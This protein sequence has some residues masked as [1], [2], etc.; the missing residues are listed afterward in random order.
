M[1]SPIGIIPAFHEGC[2]LTPTDTSGIHEKIA[3]RSDLVADDR[4]A[5]VEG[6]S[7][8]CASHLR[9]RKRC[10]ARVG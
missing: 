2:R 6:G 5:L 1:G 9:V 3:R 7:A 10:G 4:R 8:G